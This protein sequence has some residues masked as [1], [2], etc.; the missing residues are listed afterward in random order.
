MFGLCHVL[1]HLAANLEAKDAPFTVV[2]ALGDECMD[3]LFFHSIIWL[4]KITNKNTIWYDIAL[5]LEN[6]SYSM[7]DWYLTNSW[8]ANLEAV[9]EDEE[10][11]ETQ[12]YMRQFQNVQAELSTQDMT[13]LAEQEHPKVVSVLTL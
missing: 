9:E 7:I 8:W 6:H 5:E 10:N 2:M 13:A 12:A 1:W 11:G 4:W 3:L